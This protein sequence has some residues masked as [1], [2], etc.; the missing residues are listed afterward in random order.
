[1][2]QVVEVCRQFRVSVATFYQWKQ[3]LG[4]MEISE[5]NELWA[6]RDENQRL[7]RLVADLMLDKHILR[8][9][10]KKSL[11][12]ARRQEEAQS[13]CASFKVAAKR[14]CRLFLLQRSV[15]YHKGH[16]T[17]YILLRRRLRK[18]GDTRVKYGY[19]LSALRGGSMTQVPIAPQKR[20]GDLST[21][22]FDR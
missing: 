6:S 2:S 4:S 7:K 8:R 9:W 12:P 17:N 21:I 18:L 3:T 14:L 1:V 11:E 20:Y 16:P 10:S 13:I 15:F 5:L 22:T 19:R